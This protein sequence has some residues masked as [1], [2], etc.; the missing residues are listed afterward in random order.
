[1]ERETESCIWVN[2]VFLKRIYE[3]GEWRGNSCIHLR[4][5][6]MLIEK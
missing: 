3:L 2:R 4:H 1:M 5:G 6:S